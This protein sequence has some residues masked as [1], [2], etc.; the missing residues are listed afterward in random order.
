MC[1]VRYN[2]PFPRRRPSRKFSWPS[3]TTICSI[4]SFEYFGNRANSAAIQ[5]K[6]RSIPRKTALRCASLH[7]GN[8]IRTFTSAILLNPG[9]SAEKIRTTPAAKL[10]AIGRG[11][12]PSPLRMTHTAAYSIHSFIAFPSSRKFPAGR[13]YARGPPLEDS[14]SMLDSAFRDR[15]NRSHR[16]EPAHHHRR[17]N[18]LGHPHP[19]DAL[20]LLLQPSRRH[21]L[22]RTRRAAIRLDRARHGRERRLGHAASLRKALVR[23]ASALLLGRGI[24]LQALRR[25]R[26][27][28]AAAE[29][30]LCASSDAR[31][32][33]AGPTSLRRGNRPLAASS[34]SHHRRHDR[35]LSRRRHGHA[36]QRNAHDC[37]G[38]RRRR[39]GSHPKRNHADPPAHALA[40]P[41]ALRFLPGPRRPRKRPGGHHS[42]RRRHIF[43]G[44]HRQAL[45]RRL[46]P[47]SSRR[48][49]VFLLHRPPLVYPLRPPQFRFFPH[50]HHRAQFQAL[51]HPRIPA[52]PTLL[53]LLPHS[54]H[55]SSP[56]VY[57]A[58]MVR[59]PGSAQASREFSL[60]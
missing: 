13:Q 1:P 52:Y 57:L 55:R 25:E 45:A 37:H 41:A 49:R 7:S 23:K 26:S 16:R 60:A 51:P 6:F 35:L 43:L 17:P 42:L 46:P 31:A 20:R 36:I 24:K 54:S 27:R 40:G 34:A 32:G 38:L 19:C 18:R 44:A 33:L 47:L 8:A 53:V 39:P 5:P 56:L 58:D 3:S 50:L 2:T 22:R 15:S 9:S 10:L 14:G 30:H 21:R 4:F 28:R 59:T 48:S 12:T 29:R 11:N